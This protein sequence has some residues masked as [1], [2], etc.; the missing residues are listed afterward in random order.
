NLEPPSGTD[1]LIN[2]VAAGGAEYLATHLD[3]VPARIPYSIVV[4][5]RGLTRASPLISPLCH[6]D[7]AIESM[8]AMNLPITAVGN[9]EFDRGPRELLRLQRGGCHPTDGCLDGRGFPGARFQ[10]LSANVI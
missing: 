4:A 10:Y 6:N 7:P 1:G 3:D 2:G 9:H 5:A 8:N